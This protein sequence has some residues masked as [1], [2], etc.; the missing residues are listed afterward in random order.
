MDNGVGVAVFLETRK[1]RWKRRDRD[2]PR[3]RAERRLGVVLCVPRRA[4]S[5]FETCSR[6]LHGR[7]GERRGRVRRE[8]TQQEQE[9]HC[10]TLPGHSQKSLVANTLATLQQGELVVCSVASTMK[11]SYTV[12]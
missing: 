4:R 5:P 10:R 11:P 2:C 12:V 8:V 1:F 3:G 9:S 7:D 6:F